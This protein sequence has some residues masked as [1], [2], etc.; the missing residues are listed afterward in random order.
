MSS[1]VIGESW[2]G[3]LGVD[4][5]RMQMRPIRPIKA[6]VYLG[7]RGGRV[8]QEKRGL[9]KN[10][11]LGRFRSAVGGFGCVCVFVTICARLHSLMICIIIR[12]YEY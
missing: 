11:P 5:P 3:E 7:C 2:I 6:V 10:T 9:E 12:L 4:Q 1:A 8:D